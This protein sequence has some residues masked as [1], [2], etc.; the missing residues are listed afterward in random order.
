VTIEAWAEQ[1]AR[2]AEVLMLE[3]SWQ[4]KWDDIFRWL[5][6]PLWLLQQ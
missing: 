3:L 5:W 2:R 4:M 6:L 1:Q